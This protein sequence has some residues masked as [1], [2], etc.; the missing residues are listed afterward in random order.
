MMEVQLDSPSVEDLKVQIEVL[1][2]RVARERTAR[3]SAELLLEQKSM[4]LFKS[5]RDLMRL[6]ET[7]EWR[8]AERT[9]S[10]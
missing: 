5:N 1:K 4:E 3:N 10:L 7:L 9:N 8:V 6:N 2:R